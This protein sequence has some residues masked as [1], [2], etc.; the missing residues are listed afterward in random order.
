MLI[1]FQRPS[2]SDVSLMTYGSLDASEQISVSFESKYSNIHARK[3]I[4]IFRLHN[5]LKVLKWHARPWRRSFLLR[6]NQGCLSLLV[7]VNEVHVYLVCQWLGAFTMLSSIIN[8]TLSRNYWNSWL[9]LVPWWYFVTKGHCFL[10][11]VLK[12]KAQ[13]NTFDATSCLYFCLS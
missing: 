6:Y 12:I 3:R 10:V 7:D 13:K 4:W 1:T 2:C 8:R 9:I 11:K 5:G